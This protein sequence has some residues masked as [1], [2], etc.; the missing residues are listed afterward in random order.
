[1]DLLIWLTWE[2]LG[3][4]HKSILLRKTFFARLGGGG[5]GLRKNVSQIL[6]IIDFFKQRNYW[7]N[8]VSKEEYN[9]YIYIYIG[10]I[11]LSQ[12][13]RLSLNKFGICIYIGNII[14]SQTSR[15]SLNKFGICNYIL[16]CQSAPFA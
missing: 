4:I 5:G 14:L 3:K 6:V 11:I 8:L 9:I 15:L 10:N 12:T 16:D 7:K 1:M 2:I 13:S